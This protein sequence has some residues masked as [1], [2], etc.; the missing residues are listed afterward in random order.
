MPTVPIKLPVIYQEAIRDLIACQTLDEAKYFSDKAEA[1]AAWAKIYKSDQAAIESKRLKLHAYRRM[2]QLAIEL[3]PKRG[4]KGKANG[5]L[6]P[7][8]LALLRSRGFRQYDA[9]IMSKLARTKNEVFDGFIDQ[10]HPPS[11]AGLYQK[12]ANTT[13]AWKCLH[14]QSG[15][16]HNFRSW[17][18]RFNAADL[19]ASLTAD[20]TTKALSLVHECQEWLDL[21]EQHLAKRAL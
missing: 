11:P 20:E 8:P 18:R 14:L 21:F 6:A 16:P 4:V 7:G 19:A 15:S 1:L 9:Q 10:P 2:G 12:L 13:E 3:Q 17:S 5:G